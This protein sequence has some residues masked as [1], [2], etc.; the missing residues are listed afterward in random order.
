VQL[1]QAVELLAVGLAGLVALTL[2]FSQAICELLL[3]VGVGP[4]QAEDSVLLALEGQLQVALV[5]RRRRGLQGELGFKFR[6]SSP[7][8]RK[9]G[10]KK[11]RKKERKGES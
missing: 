6:L 7:S 8:L 9:K 3:Q 11:E 5:R 1:D 2:E 4:L 10:R